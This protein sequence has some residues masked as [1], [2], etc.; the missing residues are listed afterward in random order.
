MY[1]SSFLRFITIALIFFVLLI[2][3]NCNLRFSSY[4]VI[5]FISICSQLLQSVYFLMVEGTGFEGT[6][7]WHCLKDS[8]KKKTF[9]MIV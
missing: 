2:M 4:L 5:I 3:W 7:F 6:I 8:L 9:K 1:I